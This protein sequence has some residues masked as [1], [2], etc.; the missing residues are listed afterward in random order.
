[1]LVQWRRRGAGLLDR[2]AALAVAML[3]HSRWAAEQA[4]VPEGLEE[5]REV[6]ETKEVS[7]RLERPAEGRR[8]RERESMG[9]SLV[10][11]WWRLIFGPLN[12]DLLV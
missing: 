4:G 5:V 9:A 6:R 1:M 7:E 2:R 3:F 8:Q 12:S 11:T 10:G